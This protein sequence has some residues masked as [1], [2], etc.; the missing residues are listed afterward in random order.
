MP[1]GETKNTE[2]RE[3]ERF[4]FGVLNNPLEPVV[5]DDGE[6]MRFE[7][8]QASL[9]EAR[10]GSRAQTEAAEAQRDEALKERDDAESNLAEADRAA[11]GYR[12]IA[13]NNKSALDKAESELSALKA[14]VLVM[15]EA[16]EQIQ[17][18]L[19]PVKTARTGQNIDMAHEMV[20]RLKCSLRNLTLTS[21]PERCM[22][23][24][25]QRK[26]DN[27]SPGDHDN[28][29][30]TGKWKVEKTD[31]TGKAPQE[32]EELRDRVESVVQD[33]RAHGGNLVDAL[34]PLLA[35]PEAER[36]EARKALWDARSQAQDQQEPEGGDW[37][38]APT[39]PDVW[40]DVI[41]LY[42][43]VG[44]CG[45]VVTNWR[46]AVVSITDL[47][48]VERRFYAP[49]ELPSG[50]EE[51]DAVVPGAETLAF[52][53]AAMKVR[54]GRWFSGAPSHVF[55]E[56]ATALNEDGLQLM[57]TPTSNRKEGTE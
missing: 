37:D 23:C 5:K 18:Q 12:T 4:T 30:P 22:H 6:W 25:A 31:C 7:E 50:S 40:P 16:A 36:D 44:A 11:D 3:V 2:R 19:S 29:C 42:K 13:V 15:V 24:G 51:G 47:D 56:F 41:P 21:E 39:N 1:K 10:A 17:V 35:A 38:G 32:P 53:K 26:T 57:F 33:W 55:A 34:L 20:A 8:H 28:A 52:M 27:G 54:G 49:Q 9:E 45:K 46:G 43:R 14:E 48:K